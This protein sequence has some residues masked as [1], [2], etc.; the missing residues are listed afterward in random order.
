MTTILDL[1]DEIL[2]VIFRIVPQDV[3]VHRSDL[4]KWKKVCRAWY[5][6]VHKLFLEDI[7]LSQFSMLDNFI[8]SFDLNPSADYFQSIKMITVSLDPKVD[9]PYF[10]KNKIR[11]L[12]RFLNLTSISRDTTVFSKTS[13]TK[14]AN[15]LYAIFLNSITSLLIQSSVDIPLDLPTNVSIPIAT[16]AYRNISK[17]QLVYITICKF[18]TASCQVYTLTRDQVRSFQRC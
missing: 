6:P 5:L 3:A 11:T 12:S 8:T 9:R 15:P 7:H 2:Y 1:P 10:D 18:T 16:F 14:P 4:W 17:Q 13:T